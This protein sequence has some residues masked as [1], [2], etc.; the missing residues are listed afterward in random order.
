MH[1]LVFISVAR[2]IKTPY[3]GVCFREFFI[4][5]SFFVFLFVI[6]KLNSIINVIKKLLAIYFEKCLFY[7]YGFSKLALGNRKI[8][9]TRGLF[10]IL[11]SGSPF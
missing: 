11:S 7:D 6:N 3:C 5:L 4:F 9:S 2:M 8:F 10:E 1:K